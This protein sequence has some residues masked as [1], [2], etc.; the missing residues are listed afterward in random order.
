MKQVMSGVQSAWMSKL[1]NKLKKDQVKEIEMTELN[2]ENTEIK[3]K[4]THP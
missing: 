3:I 4:A 2:E 1:S